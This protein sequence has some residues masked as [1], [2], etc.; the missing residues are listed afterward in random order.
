[1]NF[2][3]IVHRPSK[4]FIYP[5]A[6]NILT[7]Q[8]ITA[9]EDVK[10]AVLFYWERYETN[11]AKRDALTL[12]VSLRD[13]YHDYFRASI[14]TNHIAAYIR[15][16][17]CLKTATETVWFGAKGFQFHEP[18][19]DENFF[20]FLWP[21]Q[22]DGFRAPNWSSR[23]VYYQIF[24]ERFYNADP[25]LSPPD[26]VP[27]G[28]APTRENHMGGDLPGILKKLDH[29]KALGATC[30]YTTPIFH[31]ASNHKYDTIN[32]YEID[33]C[34]GTKADFKRLVDEIHDRGM[35]I[36]LDGVFNHCGYGWP[37]F[38]DVAAR[39]AQS[40]YKDWFFIHTDPVQ[41][42][43]KSYDCVGHYKWMP[44]INLSN[45]DTARYFIEVGKYWIQAFG[46]DGWR[47]DVADEVPMSFWEAFSA[48]LKALKPDCL[49]LGE[50]WSDAQRLLCGNRLDSA[51]NYLFRD[52]VMLWLAQDKIPA[53][54]FDHLV[55]HA[56][57][58]YPEEVGLR[59]Y[60]PLD[61]HDTP[62][63]LFVCSGNLK[64]YR[65]AIALQMTFPGCPAIFYG[66]EVGL[67]GPNDPG[68]RLAM[69][70]DEARQNKALLQWFKQWI[71]IR[72][73]SV[74]LLQGDYHTVLCD[75]SANLY[76][77]C[78]AVPQEASL[79]LIN[80]GE[81]AC[82]R[83]LPVPCISDVWQ[84]A[85]TSQILH[86]QPCSEERPPSF[87]AKYPGILQVELPAYSVKIYQQ[88]KKEKVS[89]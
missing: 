68:C 48:E 45:P 4:E 44:K 33:P 84:D 66:D 53:S 30:I 25:S 18:G 83:T 76:G 60:N 10:E 85:L 67:S 40:P 42:D 27:W 63:F 70:W 24:P 89:L 77:Y 51:M 13:A 71:T 59:M 41:P 12:G 80:A 73:T 17:F 22:A 21:N 3:A 55:N 6:Q 75:D 37:P 16:C 52:A 87:L 43:P 79:I 35:R 46:I 62:R 82:R 54:Q 19:M 9:R 57:S 81:T 23:Q 20:E 32:Y 64:R 58:L 34:F 8:L 29:I 7:L 28:A 39:G 2:A 69:E 11:A 56:L 50:T 65:L 78:R 1:M 86:S 72:Q 88:T 74:S 26:T 5:R 36:I 15:Y 47:L 31:A 14:K 38:Q 49:L 61:S